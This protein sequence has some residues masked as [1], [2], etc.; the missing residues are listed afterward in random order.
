MAVSYL[1]RQGYGIIDRNYR[2][3]MGEIDI[4][5]E[6]KGC[7]CFVEVRSRNNPDYGFPEDTITAAKRRKIEKAALAYIKRF[8]L[9]DRPCRF[10]VISIVNTN[11]PEPGIKL[12][13]NAFDL[14]EQYR[15]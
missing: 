4:I 5:G 2:T 15:Y 11:N 9:T 6:D 3:R 1:K 10:D 13:K 8:K 12:I 7:V 14:S